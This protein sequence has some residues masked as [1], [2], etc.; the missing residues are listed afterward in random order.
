MIEL[1]N[2]KEYF[3]E[4]KLQLKTMTKNREIVPIHLGI[5]DFTEKNDTANQIYIKNKI[6]DFK[7]VG[8]D[9]TVFTGDVF[10]EVMD[11]CVILGNC[12]AIIVQL[13]VRDGVNFDPNMIPPELDCD[14]LGSDA[15]VYPATPQGIINYLKYCG[16]D[17]E[18]K[19]ATVLG[20]SDIVGKPIAQMLMEENCTV[21]QCHSKTPT[22]VRNELCKMS[23]IIIS[24]VGKPNFVTT[25]A[26]NPE[27]TQIIIDVG[28]NRN[29]E[30]KLCGDVDPQV[31]ECKN[32]LCTPV[33]GGVGLLTRLA[34]MENCL[35]LSQY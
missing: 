5:V 19:T 16:F 23:D 4:R 27:K 30:G 25:D 17:F 12:D 28:I 14:G 3:E 33:P 21:A 15:Y 34:L 6:K 13:P 18:G 7:S 9:A 2:I 29:D 11:E 35:I 8:W 10:E 26:I 32:V 20:R 22:E 31:Y 24:A 1:K